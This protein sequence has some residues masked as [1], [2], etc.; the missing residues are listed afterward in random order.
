MPIMQLLLFGYAINNDPRHLPAVL[1]DQDR[2]TMS[3][4]VAEALG[5]TGYFASCAR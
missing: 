1:L 5:A 2:S 4:S 3:R